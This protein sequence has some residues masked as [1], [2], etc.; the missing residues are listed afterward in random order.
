M[1]LSVGGAWFSAWGWVEKGWRSWQ[2]VETPPQPCPPAARGSPGRAEW[3]PHWECC[4]HGTAM[5]TLRWGLREPLPGI[6]HPLTLRLVAHRLTLHFLVHRPAQ[7]VHTSSPLPRASVWL[8]LG[9]SGMQAV[10]TCCS[11]QP[12]S[13]V[14][15]L[16]S[17][18][19]VQPRHFM[20]LFGCLPAG[21]M[22][23]QQGCFPPRR[24]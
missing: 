5:P 18:G 11:G 21:G 24:E 20:A 19:E 9:C 16:P 22:S 2:E 3:G 1:S 8:D 6:S 12:S 7:P 14:P 13:E 15:I 10:W 17:L 4:R 23:K